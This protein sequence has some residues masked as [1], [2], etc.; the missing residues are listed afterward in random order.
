MHGTEHCVSER[1]ALSL[2]APR[3][4]VY[5]ASASTLPGT[6]QLFSKTEPFARNGLFLAR[7]G[8]RLRGYH[9]GVKGPGLLLRSLACRLSCPFGFLAPL[10]AAGSPQLPAASTPQA[11]C[12]LT[13][14]L[15]RL[16]PSCRLQPSALCTRNGLLHTR[17]LTLC[18]THRLLHA[19]HSTSL[20]WSRIAP[21]STLA[22]PLRIPC[23]LLRA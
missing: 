6:P 10:P 14:L 2:S 1:R 20:C 21:C 17:H 8:L 4:P 11:R 18:A 7:N 19:L 3:Q 15:C 22:A 5:P 16:C 9:S 12:I 23:G 13:G